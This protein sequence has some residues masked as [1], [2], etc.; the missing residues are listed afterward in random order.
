MSAD[1][2]APQGVPMVRPTPI[3]DGSW[4]DDDGCRWRLRGAG[5][6]MPTKR[7]Q[8]LLESSVARVLVIGGADYTP[9]EISYVDREALWNRISPYLQDAVTRFEGDHTEVRVG[10]FKDSSHRSMLIVEEYC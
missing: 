3:A 7:V 10:E 5:Q 9:S 2:D 4:T 8:H 1:S 6:R